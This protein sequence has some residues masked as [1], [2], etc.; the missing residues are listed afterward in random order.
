MIQTFANILVFDMCF[1]APYCFF[2]GFWALKPLGSW[3]YDTQC[4]HDKDEQHDDLSNHK[5]FTVGQMGKKLQN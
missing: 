5:I 3:K 1:E 4:D 2:L